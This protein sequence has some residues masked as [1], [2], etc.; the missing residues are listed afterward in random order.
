[1]KLYEAI[2]E[3]RQESKDISPMILFCSTLYWAANIIAQSIYSLGDSNETAARI[4][5]DSIER[6][7]S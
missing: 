1:M 6:A 5:S 3:V 2:T 7:H 4:V